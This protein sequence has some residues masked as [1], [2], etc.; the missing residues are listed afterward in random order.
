MEYMTEYFTYLIQLN[1]MIIFQQQWGGA[2]L[3][4]HEGR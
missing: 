3:D 4:L 2:T 1:V